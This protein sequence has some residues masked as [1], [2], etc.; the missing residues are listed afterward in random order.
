MTD[1]ALWH[2]ALQGTLAQ[3]AQ[4]INSSIGIDQRMWRQDID[5]SI[6]HAQMLGAQG[7]VPASSARRM[8]EGLRSIR[9]DIDGGRLAIDHSCEDIHTF[10]EAELTRRIGDEGKM[11]HTAR[12]RNDQ[13]ALDL[14][15]YLRDEAAELDGLLTELLDALC[16]LA[17][18]HAGTLMPGMTHLQHAQPVTVG[19]HLMAYGMMFLRDRARL[20]DA[21]SR[22]NESPLGAGALAGTG[23]PIDR[24]QTAQAMGFAGSCRNS[25]DAVSD[26]DFVLEL[27]SMLTISMMHL[28]RLS[29]ELILWATQEFGFVSFGQAFSTGSSIMPQKRNPDVAEL[30]RG[31][32]GRVYGSLMNTLVMLK[33]LPLAYNKD[34]QE[35]K[36]AVFDAVDT[37]KLCLA[38]AAPMLRT[39]TFYPGRM[40]EAAQQ[41]Y[42]NATDLADYLAA[43]GMP[44]RD[45][46]QLSARIVRDC[47]EKRLTLEALSLADY[48]RYS[49]LIGPD[50]HEALSLDSCLARRGSFGG[51]AP[52]S[53]RE[54]IAWV[55]AQIDGGS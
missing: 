28:S 37:A 41:G 18:E 17:E 50:I 43:R 23:H 9:E 24:G 55:R 20:R 1:S 25:L 35:D 3:Q 19:H 40:R 47:A 16:G 12:S 22:M 36:E 46:Y 11:L 51:T 33:S 53:V 5:G 34:M 29:E 21:A 2:S 10:V 39:L 49:S 45:A 15:L 4:A 54:Q 7:I 27:Q 13:V 52:D 42:L 44:F 14:R 6:A 8:A 30:I 48:Q 32:A 31:K 26:R 38:A